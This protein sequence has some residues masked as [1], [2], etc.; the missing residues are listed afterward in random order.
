MGNILNRAMQLNESFQIVRRTYQNW[1][2]VGYNLKFSKL[3]VIAI[4][5]KGVKVNITDY[6]KV[7]SDYLIVNYN[8]L[9]NYN[10]AFTDP[11]AVFLYNEYKYLNKCR[12]MKILDIGA[13][14]GDSAIYFIVNGAEKVI[15]IEPYPTNF[16]KL[17]E[18]IENNNLEDKI[19]ALNAVLGCKEGNMKININ[20]EISTGSDVVEATDGYNI[21]EFTLQGLISLYNLNDA[22]LKMDC[23]GCEYKSI[24]TSSKETLRKFSRMQIEYHYGYNDLVNK[25]RDCGFKVSY[26][27]PRSDYNRCASN[28]NMSVGYLYALR[29]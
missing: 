21:K 25:L 11:Y 19:I 6:N 23:E 1:M 7:V 8:I 14:I 27:K 3:P 10:K 17:V 16:F 5:K 29:I 28:P 24:I 12:N 20:K 22:Y 26:T 15:A 18:N 4:T 9:F 13:N 2:K